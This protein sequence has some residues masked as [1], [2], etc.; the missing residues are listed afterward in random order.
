MSTFKTESEALCT[1][2]VG[3]DDVARNEDGQWVVHKTRDAL[4]LQSTHLMQGCTNADGHRQPSD[5]R[6]TAVPEF[7]E[8]KIDGLAL[9]SR[10]YAPYKSLSL[11]YGAGKIAG[12]YCRLRDIPTK[13]RGLWQHG[14]LA[15]YRAVDPR[16]MAAETVQDPERE[17]CWVARKDQ[18]EYL[19]RHGY[20]A[21]AIGL[22]IAYVPDLRHVRKPNSLLVMPA[23]SMDFTT[24]QWCFA[25]YVEA[26]RQIRSD[27]DEVVACVHP[28]CVRKN[29]WITEF[30]R[31]EIPV[32]VGA[33]A[34]D[35]NSLARI[36]A[37]MSQFEFVTTNA[38]GSCIVYAAAFGA[39]LS[40]YGPF[41]EPGLED[42][43][44]TIFYHDNPGLL[45]KILPGLSFEAVKSQFPEF[46]CHPR[47]AEE[48]TQWGLNEIGYPNRIP[49]R[50]MKQCFG[51][52]VLGNSIAKAKQTAYLLGSE[53]LPQK[54]KRW[55]KEA[56]SPPV[57]A[58][59]RQVAR[60]HDYP[61]F[62]VGR[63]T[64]NGE[65]F[66]FSDAPTFLKSYKR[67]FLEHRYDFPSVKR[68][69]T[70][71]DCGA[72]I[73]LGVRYWTRKYPEAK[74]LAFEP[75]PHLFELLKKN[76]EGLS[77]EQICLRNEAV[78][79]EKGTLEFKS[80]RLGIGQLSRFAQD[81]E[82]TK[83]TVSTVRLSDF[84]DLEIDFLKIDIEGAEV[85]V[86]IDCASKLKNVKRIYIEYHSYLHKDQRLESI[87]RVL[88]EAGFRY[89]IAPEAFSPRPFFHLK[90]K[91]GM[92]QRLYIWGYHG[93]RFP[94][95]FDATT[96]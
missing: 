75:D 41:C 35:R 18:E 13:I 94:R 12:E 79:N 44:E 54:P 19:R 72:N 70:I 32:I 20:Q 83:M 60:L 52:T 15:E 92:D 80:T 68:A 64:V 38:Y 40:I 1:G 26:I 22:P 84:L 33:E 95:T 96:S 25:E 36:K 58:F 56:L 62:T 14:W 73:G 30:Q 91:F 81:L 53:M 65:N 49:P 11:Q 87:L 42:F 59:N 63:S 57:R 86:V 51:W 47:E 43:E 89:H 90:A 17:C 45:Q 48:R 2:E 88:R 93:P 31:A 67:I 61:R 16:Y 76:C 34:T 7:T 24:H 4:E 10:D 77:A 27:F 39:K 8:G 23:H 78:W 74:I 71:I 50:E 29:Y 55:I 82:G 5:S 66:H 21:R 3:D 6:L 69:L 28:A 46:F 85:E 37:L 9:P